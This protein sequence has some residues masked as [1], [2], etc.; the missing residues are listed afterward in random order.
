MNTATTTSLF[1]THGR[2][3]D[4]KNMNGLI[5]ILNN[6]NARKVKEGENMTEDQEDTVK[7]LKST[8][9]TM[10]DELGKFNAGISVDRIDGYN[11]MGMIMG[12]TM[13]EALTSG[14]LT[15]K[16]NKGERDKMDIYLKPIHLCGCD[17]MES[18]LKE[19]V[20]K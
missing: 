13:L 19:L 18:T 14:N 9:R 7:I 8:L 1:F 4:L 2:K 3:V 16:Q 10:L 12:N 17:E 11:T 20:A 6:N 5:T 15:N